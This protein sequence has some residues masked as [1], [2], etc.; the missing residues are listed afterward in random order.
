MSFFDRFRRKPEQRDVFTSLAVPPPGYGYT[1]AAGM[2]VSEQTALQS[3]VVF[4]C[5][6]LL[7]DSVA[8]L[9]MDA[10]RKQGDQ[11]VEVDPQPSLITKPCSTMTNFEWKF[12]TVFSMAIRGNSYQLITARDALE[13]PTDLLPIHP[14]MVQVDRDKD[15]GKLI[16]K[17][18]GTKVPTADM[19]HIRRFPNPGGLQSLSPIGQAAQGI[20]LTLA[21]E[22]Y[23]AQYFAGAA[24]PTSVLETDQNLSKDQALIVQKDWI[25]SHGGKRNPAVLSGGLKWRAISIPPDESQFLETRKFQR[26]EIAML[27][28]V[29]PHMIGDVEKSTSWG[30]GIEQQSI[31]FVTYTLQPWLTCIEDAISSLLPRGQFMKFNVD[32]LL[33]GDSK[34]R[35]EAYVQ[36]RTAGWLSVN[37]IRALEDL[38]PVPEGDTYI[39]PLNMGPLGTDPTK[40]PPAAPPAPEGPD[41]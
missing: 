14:D 13:R 33:R 39:Q 38:P 2:P 16:Y 15:T 18:G 12:A 4:A 36:A 31:G 3:I 41:A 5:A 8:G 32:G 10:F 35:F 20:G 22:Q 40:E 6:R 29:P 30:T 23:G 19:L 34:S 21:A 7:G 26:N 28:G 37:E 9:P 24:N 11:R 27:F 25:A 17:V 1:S